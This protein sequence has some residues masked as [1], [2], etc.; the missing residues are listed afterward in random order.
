MRLEESLGRLVELWETLAMKA[1]VKGRSSRADVS[2]SSSNSDSAVVVSMVPRGLPRSSTSSSPELFLRST[3]ASKAAIPNSSKL[4]LPSPPLLN[5]GDTPS[6]FVCA[7]DC[8][9]RELLW[10]SVDIV[11]NP[12]KFIRPPLTYPFNLGLEDNSTSSGLENSSSEHAAWEDSSSEDFPSPAS[13]G[14][15]DEGRHHIYKKLMTEDELR[16][17]SSKTIPGLEDKGGSNGWIV[18]DDEQG[19]PEDVPFPGLSE[20]ATGLDDTSSEDSF[21]GL[22]LKDFPTKS[23][24]SHCL[25]TVQ[26]CHIG[27]LAPVAC[28]VQNS[29]TR[30]SWAVLDERGLL[31]CVASSIHDPF[32]Y[33]W[34]NEDL[35][36]LKLFPGSGSW[37]PC[38]PMSCKRARPH[39]WALGGKIYV[40]GGLWREDSSSAWCEVYDPEVDKWSTLPEPKW[41][42]YPQQHDDM[43]T[44]VS[45]NPVDGRQFIF[46]GFVSRRELYLLDVSENKWTSLGG[47][48]DFSFCSGTYLSAVGFILY[49]LSPKFVMYAYDIVTRTLVSSPASVCFLLFPECPFDGCGC[50]LA[51]IGGDMFCLLYI[52]PEQSSELHPTPESNSCKGLRDAEYRLHCS[53]L[54]VTFAK[55]FLS[56]SFESC[57]SYVVQANDCQKVVVMNPELDGKS[58]L[59]PGYLNE[60]FDVVQTEMASDEPVCHL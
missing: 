38:A 49:W 16:L 23:I 47:G 15:E 30:D 12:S 55:P 43:F 2:A 19:M 17:E 59:L 34:W 42:R 18:S 37:Y 24:S 5:A 57:Q 28:A 31:C 60:T 25:H 45:V 14:H 33:R 8:I 1:K 29:G 50:L 46:V 10:Y 53:K 32:T 36:C 51:H 39:T 44:A 48:H 22:R 20:S 6:L 7:Y 52:T 54:R 35:S 26:S 4:L 56:I 11:H 40:F 3:S 58:T 27:Y 13:P 9:E 41:A 21:R